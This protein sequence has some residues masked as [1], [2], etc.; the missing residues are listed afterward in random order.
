MSWGVPATTGT[1]VA[2]KVPNLPQRR[3]L[4]QVGFLNELIQVVTWALSLW[5]F[6]V[7]KSKLFDNKEFH[8][9]KKQENPFISKSYLNGSN[10]H[11][12]HIAPQTS[13]PTILKIRIVQAQNCH[14]TVAKIATVSK[15]ET[16]ASQVEM[17]A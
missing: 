8:V 4:W 7:P 16:V 9:V 15:L 3:F 12:L 10:M 5:I 13:S 1:A 6:L 2:R 17:R 11:K 14:P